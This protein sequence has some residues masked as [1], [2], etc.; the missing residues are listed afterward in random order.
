MHGGNFYFY[1]HN[2]AGSHTLSGYWT[3]DHLK[4]SHAASGGYVLLGAYDGQIEIGS[5]NDSQSYIDFHGNA[6]LGR[7]YTGRILYNDNGSTF[8]Y[9]GRWTSGS[10]IRLKKDVVDMSGALAKIMRLRAVNFRWKDPK[11]DTGLEL[12]V[13]AQEVEQVFPELVKSDKDGIKSVDYPKFSVVLL[14]ALKDQQSEIDSL[15][16]DIESIKAELVSLKKAANA[17]R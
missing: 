9:Y 12:G 13:I 5:G 15:K 11:R 10:D 2:A 8:I 16:D 3:P 1:T 4:V 6:N 14:G 17:K 7:D